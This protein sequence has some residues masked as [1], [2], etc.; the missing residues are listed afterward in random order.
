MIDLS[1]EIDGLV[2]V[3]FG[4]SIGRRQRM[5]PHT[6]APRKEVTRHVD[7]TFGR[8]DLRLSGTSRNMST[9]GM[10]VLSEDPKP[11]GTPVH[12]RFDEFEGWGEV[13]WQRTAEEGGSWLGMKFTSLASEDRR[14]LLVLLADAPLYH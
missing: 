13:V 7:L 3:V 5:T 8:S 12:F 9:T 4:A 10:L 2:V 6:P 14:R 11:P 1:V